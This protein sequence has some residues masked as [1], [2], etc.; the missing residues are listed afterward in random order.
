MTPSS[1]LSSSATTNQV[2]W[3]VPIQNLFLNHL[4][5]AEEIKTNG[6]LDMGRRPLI[7]I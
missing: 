1:M 4:F 3:L 2:I 6:L 5:L 7:F